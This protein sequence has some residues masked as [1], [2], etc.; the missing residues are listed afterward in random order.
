MANYTVM[1][2]NMILGQFLPGLIKDEKIINFYNEISRENFL[3]DSLKPLAYSDLNIRTNIKR[4]LP[5]P[6][7]SAKI[8]QEANLQSKEII[9]LIG[10]NYGYE[11]AILSKIVD[12][13]I[14]LEED[15]EMKNIA[16]ENIKKNALENIVIINSMHEKG[17]KKLGP[18]DTII[19]LDP[20]IEIKTVLLDQLVDG[21][22]LFFFEKQN[23]KI[24][25]SKLSVFFKVNKKYIKQKL[26]D[27]NM[28]SFINNTTNDRFDFS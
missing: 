7:N 17:N 28:P 3:P 24:Q 4:C 13:V 19:S 26:F 1:K 25:E 2:K 9:L 15:K 18:Y 16:E 20:D 8:F 22:K 23:Y 12:T 27:L 21:G 11:A 6:F 5:S 10:A 14:A